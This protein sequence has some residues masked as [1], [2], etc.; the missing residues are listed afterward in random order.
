MIVENPFVNTTLPLPDTSRADVSIQVTLRNLQSTPVSGSLSGH[1]GG[2]E[3]SQPVQ[4]APSQAVTVSVPTIHL[5]NPE[6][7]WPNGY[8]EPNLYPVELNFKTDTGV[9]SDRK[10]FRPVFANSP[11]AKMAAH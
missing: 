5:Q 6:L 11:I 7:W 3:L 1:F 8:G 9:L 10:V 4:L 2:R